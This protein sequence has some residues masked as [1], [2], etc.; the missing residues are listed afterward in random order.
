MLAD[1]F[2]R[3]DSKAER[4]KAAGSPAKKFR[5]WVEA[6]ASRKTLGGHA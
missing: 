4:A 2:V 3:E 6:N 1:R 5:V